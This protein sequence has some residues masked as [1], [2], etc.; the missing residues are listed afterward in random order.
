MLV[1]GSVNGGMIAL[2]AAAA[3][4][5]LRS[6]TVVEPPAFDVVRGDPAVEELVRVSSEHYVAQAAP[7][8]NDVL[9]RFVERASAK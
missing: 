8:F 3:A 1:H 6:L 7:G 5:G 2:L 9:A 4:S